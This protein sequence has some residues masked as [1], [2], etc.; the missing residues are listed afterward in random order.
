MDIE[1]NQQWIRDA[2]QTV[3]RER[4]DKQYRE[5]EIER[6][7]NAIDRSDERIKALFLEIHERTVRFP[8]F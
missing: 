4:V 2:L 1:E 3:H 8:F 6:H 7:K 5:D